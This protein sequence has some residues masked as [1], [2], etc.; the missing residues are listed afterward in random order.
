MPDILKEEGRRMMGILIDGRTAM[1]VYALTFCLEVMI[2]VGIYVLPGMYLSFIL[3]AVPAV[4]E[5]TLWL[6]AIMIAFWTA[7]YSMADKKGALASFGDAVFK[8][9]KFNYPRQL[10]WMA[11][12]LASFLFFMKTGIPWGTGVF[13]ISLMA[14]GFLIVNLVLA[15][16]FAIIGVGVAKLLRR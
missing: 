10:L 6:A 4:F 2:G 9:V 14:L 8:M 3:L 13:N 15:A 5:A 16:V 12:L 7:Y 11:G 1:A